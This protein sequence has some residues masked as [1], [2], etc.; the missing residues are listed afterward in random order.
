MPISPFTKYS[1][2]SIGNARWFNILPVVFVMYTIAQIERTSIGFALPYI[3]NELGL[4]AT[5][6]GMVGG[7]FAW[8]YVLTQLIS[9]W[10]TLSIGPRNLIGIALILWGF[11]SLGLA[12]VDGYAELIV[13]RIIIGIVQ[14]PVF[15]ATST[16]LSQ[17]FLKE[18]RSRAFGI[19]NLSSPVGAFLTGPISGLILA[20]WDWRVML[21]AEGL[22]AWLW[23]IMWWW[24]VPASMNTPRWL[25][26]EESRNVAAELAAEQVKLTRS[27]GDSWW[28]V[29]AEPAVW[30]TLLGF[31]L[32]NL[33]STGFTI[34]LPTILKSFEQLSIV[35]IGW[36]SGLPA[37]AGMFGILLISRHSDKHGQERRWH[38]AIPT[39]LAGMLMSAVAF[40]PSPF[41]CLQIVLFVFVGFT[42]KMFLPLIFVRLTE[43]LPSHK[44]AHA[45]ALTNGFGNLLGG[46]IGPVLIGY[47]KQT[48]NGFAVPLFILGLAGLMGGFIFA[49]I[50]ET[51]NRVKP[52]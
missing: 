50:R 9:G 37:L 2:P 40:L 47:L 32:I 49:G 14:G 30:L 10:L 22:P 11:G 44:S 17:W 48:T 16:L 31:S 29:L 28:T 42:Q 33:M 5:Q 27:K 8:G 13:F 35:A 19:W 43:I 26:E 45:I 3:T 20:Q 7:V 51:A 46:S 1:R 21:I 15:A 4:T 6:A 18:E 34:W 38:A 12:F 52:E 23:A 36:L 41:Y 39:L 24:R 25:P